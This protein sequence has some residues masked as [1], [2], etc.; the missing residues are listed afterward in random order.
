[1]NTEPTKEDLESPIFNAIWDVVKKWHVDR[2]EGYASTTTKSDAMVIL[3]AIRAVKNPLQIKFRDDIPKEEMDRLM[4]EFLNTPQPVYFRNPQLDVKKEMTFE[5]V[6]NFFSATEEF[7]VQDLSASG[8]SKYLSVT[9]TDNA[10]G[11]IIKKVKCSTIM[12]T[13]INIQTLVRVIQKLR[14]NMAVKNYD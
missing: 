1:M 7:T 10:P 14:Y 3:N 2:N 9:L 12:S 6:K 4:N 8:Q 13:R 11:S 5:E